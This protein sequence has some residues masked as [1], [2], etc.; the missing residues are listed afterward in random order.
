MPGP[1]HQSLVTKRQKASLGYFAS[2]KSGHGGD[3]LIPYGERQHLRLPNIE[4]S[5]MAHMGIWADEAENL[6]V[7]MVQIGKTLSR[8]RNRDPTSAVSQHQILRQTCSNPWNLFAITL[9]Q[10]HR[11]LLIASRARA[12]LIT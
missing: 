5:I 11:S 8:H 4:E 7:S 2:V 1:G 10:A 12:R 3:W 6:H 9:A